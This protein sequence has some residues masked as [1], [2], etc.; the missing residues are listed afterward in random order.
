MDDVFTAPVLVTLRRLL[1][2]FPTREWRLRH[3]PQSPWLAVRF[4][5][6]W[7]EEATPA[8][9]RQHFAIWLA[10]A[11]AY[12]ILDEAVVG[13]PIPLERLNPE[14]DVIGVQ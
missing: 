13:E 1:C 12:E 10:T 5:P 11:A 3:E 6:A 14:R 7:G 4:G 8:N 2:F 9:G